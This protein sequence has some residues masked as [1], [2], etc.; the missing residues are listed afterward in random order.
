MQQSNTIAFP[1]TIGLDLGSKVTQCAIYGADCERIEERKVATNRARISELLE[2]FPGARV[3]MEASTPSRWIC[4]LAQGLGHEVVVANPRN[5]PIITSSTRKCDRNDA[6]LLAELGQLRPDLLS[7]VTLREDRFQEVRALLFARKQLVG[8]RSALV[9]FI[10]SEVR[11]TGSSLPSCG[12]KVFVS[13]CR[14][15]VPEKLKMALGPVFDLIQSATDGIRTYDK[16]IE[17][18][19]EHDFSETRL[20]RQVHGVGPLVALAFVATIGDPRRFQ[21]PRAIGAYLGLVPR[22]RQS[23]KSDPALSITKTGDRTM[24][25]LLVSA[26]TRILA[27]TGADSDLRRFGER[28]ASQGGKRAK[29]RARIAVARKL[30]IVL[31]ALLRTGEVYEPLRNSDEVDTQAA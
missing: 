15:L 25:T 30:G 26:A 13:K 20:L 8:Q 28:I 9:T 7:P 19:S 11:V 2:R 5:I 29:A 12:T 18:L 24:R 4:S 10:R 3:V 21:K 17:E 31:H 23:G 1:L 27:N 14:S 16:N 6:R 22:I